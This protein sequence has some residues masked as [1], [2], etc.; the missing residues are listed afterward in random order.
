[1]LPTLREGEW[2]LARRR[3]FGERPCNRQI[4]ILLRREFPPVLI[5]RV[6]ASPGEA[7]PTDAPVAQ[8]NVPDGCYLLAGDNP[9][10]H[11][12]ARWIGPVS[13]NDIWGMAFLVVWPWRRL[14]RVV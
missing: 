11:P 1:M 12:Q 8:A 13:R 5:K 10:L 3:F 2:V 14:R 9:S 7:V 6:V 4:M